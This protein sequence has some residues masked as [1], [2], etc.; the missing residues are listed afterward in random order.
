MPLA[1][2]FHVIYLDS[3]LLVQNLSGFTPSELLMLYTSDVTRAFLMKAVFLDM[4][5]WIIY[6]EVRAA[7]YS[8]VWACIT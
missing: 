3:L 8:S 5:G 2:S 1:V 4:W 7:Q 6:E